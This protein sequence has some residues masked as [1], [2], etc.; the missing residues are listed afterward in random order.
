MPFPKPKTLN[1]NYI[2]MAQGHKT[3]YK[4]WLLEFIIQMR[5]IH[6]IVKFGGSRTVSMACTTPFVTLPSAEITFDSLTTTPS[7][8]T[9]RKEVGVFSLVQKFFPNTMISGLL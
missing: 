1:K 9:E 2:K 3:I 5:L 7:E 4:K 6:G 8:E